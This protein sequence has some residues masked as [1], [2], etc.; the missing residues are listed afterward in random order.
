[1]AEIACYM[2]GRQWHP[3]EREIRVLR[4]GSAIIRV[5][6]GWKLFSILSEKSD[7]HPQDGLDIKIEVTFLCSCLSVSVV[8]VIASLQRVVLILYHSHLTFC[9]PSRW[10]YRCF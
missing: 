3:L 10:Y 4:D 5:D 8:H 1:M 6:N 9:K 7:P 2:F